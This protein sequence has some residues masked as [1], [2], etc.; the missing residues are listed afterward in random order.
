MTDE[1]FRIVVGFLLIAG[2]VLAKFLLK[3]HARRNRKIGKKEIMS[4]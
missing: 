4:R 1:E 3:A 2:A